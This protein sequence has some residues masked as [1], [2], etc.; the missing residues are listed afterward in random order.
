[1]D[2]IVGESLADRPLAGLVARRKRPSREDRRNGHTG[3]CHGHCDCDLR[4]FQV[5]FRSVPAILG[6]A[7]ARWP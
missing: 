7:D 5:W 2:H 1:M 6:V 4:R 3:N